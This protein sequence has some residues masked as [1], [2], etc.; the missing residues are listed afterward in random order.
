MDHPE[1]SDAQLVALVVEGDTTAF[2]QIMARYQQSLYQLAYRMVMDPF[3]AEDMLQVIFLQV[4]RN[5]NKFRLEGSFRAWVFTIARNTCLNE[6]RRRRRKPSCSLDQLEDSTDNYSFQLSDDSQPEANTV[7]LQDELVDIL[8]HVLKEVPEKQRTALM[9]FQQENLSY[10][11]IS[12]VLGCSTGATKSLIFRAREHLK[13]RLKP[14]LS[15]GYW[16]P[17]VVSNKGA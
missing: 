1:I 8:N 10:E 17:A 16:V 7:V 15:D 13:A 3:E 12:K 11:E 14:Y 4:Y 5:L 6:I 9:L 2:R